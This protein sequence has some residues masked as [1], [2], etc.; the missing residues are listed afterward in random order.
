MNRSQLV[1]GRSPRT[2]LLAAL[3]SLL[4]AGACGGGNDAATDD[5]GPA[6]ATKSANTVTMRLVAFKPGTIDVEPG[7]TVTWKQTDAG[8]HTVTSGTVEQGTGGVTERPDDRFD[9]GDI[10]KGRTYEFTFAEAGT[11]PYFCAIHPATMRGEVRV[12]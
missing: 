4:L 8:A 7:A 3:A 9:S 12:A 11:Y 5:A 6:A 2:L 1:A 10:A